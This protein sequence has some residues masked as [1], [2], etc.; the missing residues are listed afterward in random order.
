HVEAALKVSET[1]VA[2]ALKLAQESQSKAAVLELD[3][4]S[5]LVVYADAYTRKTLSHQTKDRNH[6][7]KRIEQTIFKQTRNLDAVLRDLP[8]E[9]REVIEPQIGEVKKVR[10]RAI[11]DLV[12]SGQVINSSN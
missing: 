12:G 6:C 3:V 9:S 8:V 5:S 7:L 11:N 10:L 1:R 4:F 2:N